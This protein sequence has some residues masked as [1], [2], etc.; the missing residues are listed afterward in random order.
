[1]TLFASLPILISI[2][3]SGSIQYPSPIISL[4]RPSP[5]IPSIALFLSLITK[6]SHIE[7]LLTTLPMY[8][9]IALCNSLIHFSLSIITL[10]EPSPIYL[11]IA[12]FSAKTLPMIFV[13]RTLI[14]AAH[15]RNYQF[16]KFKKII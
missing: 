12:L 9:F 15:F 7:T 1:M 4:W 10:W 3:L 5:I 13:W 8:L 11:S 6:P 2:A 16:L 14:F